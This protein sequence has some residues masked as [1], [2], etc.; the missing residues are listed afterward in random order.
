MPRFTDTEVTLA[1]DTKIPA[2]LTAGTKGYTTPEAVGDLVGIK[3]VGSSDFSYRIGTNYGEIDATV[4]S[5]LLFDGASS[6]PNKIGIASVKPVDEPGWGSRTADA[7]YVAGA[8][9]LAINLGYD[10]V[11]NAL[12]AVCISMHGF[13]ESTATHA[14]IFGGSLHTILSGSDYA[15]CFGGLNNQIQADCDYGVII[16]GNLNKLE[17]GSSFPTDYGHRGVAI[18]GTSNNVS[19]Q[20]GTIISGSANTVTSQKGTIINGVSCTVSGLHGFATGDSNTVSGA[21]SV[22]FGNSNTVS[23]ARSL[24]V[25][26]SCTVA[27]EYALA[28]GNGI[29]PPTNGVGCFSGRQRA[30]TAGNNQTYEFN[31]SQETTGAETKDLSTYGSTNYPAIPENCV[32]MG[33]FLVVGVD[34]GTGASGTA[35]DTC[36]YKIT[37]VLIKRGAGATAAEVIADTVTELTDGIT[38]TDPSLNVSAAA[39]VF[40]VRVNGAANKNIAW[41]ASFQGHMIKFA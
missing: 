31:C 7:G 24:I 33:D 19:G 5:A 20:F 11:V 12:A 34:L 37:N 1:L 8:A 16:G 26:T 28:V 14:G 39:S 30:S 2:Q 25:G 13:V 22:A 21:Y 35:G 23:G 29:V 27:Y 38:V 10:N 17:T 3:K 4:T 41:N 36:A 15:A 32:I 6:Y 9:D 40:R 18:G